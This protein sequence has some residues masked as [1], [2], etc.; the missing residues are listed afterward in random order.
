MMAYLSA[1]EDK[2]DPLPSGMQCFRLAIS[3]N[4]AGNNTTSNIEEQEPKD[5]YRRYAAILRPSIASVIT[6][7]LLLQ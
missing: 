7:L 4:I 1:G 3:A 5:I 2:G 6:A